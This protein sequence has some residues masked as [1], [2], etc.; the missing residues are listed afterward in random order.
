ML[1]SLVCRQQGAPA[2]KAV[3]LW[4]A[5]LE[6][7]RELRSPDAVW[8][9]ME[10]AAFSQQPETMHPIVKAMAKVVP[11]GQASEWEFAMNLR[12]HHACCSN[13]TATLLVRPPA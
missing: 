8:V 5:S 3:V 4:G 7:Q 10:A 11:E 1:E 13:L 2:Q 6:E 12:S 9:P